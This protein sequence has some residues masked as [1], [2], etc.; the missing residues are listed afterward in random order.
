[1]A[2]FGSGLVIGVLLLA[3]AGVLVVADSGGMS[4]SMPT[5]VVSRRMARYPA[6]AGAVLVVVSLAGLA[7]R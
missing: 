5:Q 6:V 3:V 1:M 2:V 4:R 7:Y